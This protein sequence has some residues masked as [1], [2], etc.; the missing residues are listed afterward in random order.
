[1]QTLLQDLRYGLRM[2]GKRPGFTLVAVITLALGIGANTAIFSV[3]NALVLN[4]PAIAEPERVAAIWRSPLDR[5]VEG[6]I[7][8][9]NLQ[10]WQTR[11][12]SFETIAAYKPNGFILLRDGQAE[13]VQGMRVTAN[14]LS[15]LKVRVLRGRDFQF[16]EERRGAQPVVILGHDFWQTQF[17]GNEAALGQS[18]TLNG[19]L[20]TIIGVLPPGFEFPL[21]GK[22]IQLVTTIAGEGGNLDQRGAQVLR[23]IGRL[24]PGVS[25][26]QAQ[27]EMTGIADS[28]AGQYPQYNRNATA[29]VVRVDEQLV[30]HD[31]R[32]ALWVLLGA[33][34][35]ILL[36]ACT[37]VT[38]LLLVRA[39]AR[40]KELALRAALGAS[41]W[42]IIR[43]L[44]TESLVLSLLAGG[45]GLLVAMWGLSAIKHYGAN[46]LPR[47]D[48]VQIN[49]K[50]LVFTLAV[51]V[52]TA[53]LFSLLPVIK[54]SRP[55]INELLKGGAKSVTSSRSLRVWRDSLVVTEVALGLVLLVGAGLMIRSFA[56]LVNVDPGFDPKNVLTG[57]I[58]MTRALYQAHDERVRYVKQTLERLKAMP[59]V[60]SAAF[61]APMPFSGGN[62][63]SD[64]RIEGRPAPEPGQE[65]DANN[66]SVTVD[67]FEAIK[68]PLRRGRYF[69]EQDQRGG[70]G[71]AIINETLA[72][73]YFADEDPI[74]KRISHIG[75]NQNEGDP[76]Q[77]EIVGVVGDVHHSSL[78]R[79]ANPEI[80][81]PYQQNSWDWGNF[82]VRTTHAP[83]ALTGS[84]TEA[85]RSGDRTVPVTNV[86]PLAEAIRGTVAETQFY[87]LLFALFGATG[88]ILTLTG[89]YGVIA[90]TVSQRTQ[91]IGI[92]MAL[93]GQS[94]D[95][96]RLFVGKGMMLTAA[97]IAIGVVV[98][99]ALTRLMAN[100]LFGLSPTDPLT[101]AVIALLLGVVALVA[102][103]IPARRA[104]KIDPMAALRYE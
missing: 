71:V 12:Q 79:A 87:T 58:S 38:N 28:L 54:A 39:S 80:Y 40:E 33:V 63:G 34:G 3:I 90:Y 92:R 68:I 75:A 1:M 47:L 49:A 30:G 13:R 73:R 57:R 62:V 55:E 8:Y 53:L 14:F 67:Y 50:V 32:R 77:F 60:E 95:V 74:G 86:Q 42:Q 26:A 69:T 17:G 24:Q 97:G 94:K 16:E 41:R 6:Y 70:T 22:D 44:L 56:M 27:A 36:I 31:V 11:S 65:P 19:K 96:L 84:F 21:A 48:E 61:V 20:F 66:R 2:L 88:L 37:N 82:L 102:C 29:Y 15:L 59:G 76:E 35:F 81:L 104:T 72:R 85:V 100:L 78:T 101:F 46:Q 23:A 4:P 93:G 103:Y 45:A 18:L 89:I 64:F 99:V 98:A 91:E 5:R 10:D 7:S 9:L 83:A 25:M 43:Q 51:S 52:L